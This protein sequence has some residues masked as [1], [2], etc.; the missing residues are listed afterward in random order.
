MKWKIV[1]EDHGDY[2]PIDGKLKSIRWLSA[3]F[4]RPKRL[5]RFREGVRVKVRALKSILRSRCGR[6][7]KELRGLIVTRAIKRISSGVMVTCD[8]MTDGGIT[9]KQIHLIVYHISF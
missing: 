6:W 8:T 2:I 5:E 7:K 3:V 4:R 9:L 1:H